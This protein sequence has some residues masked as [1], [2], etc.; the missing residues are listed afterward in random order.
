[1]SFDLHALKCLLPQYL[2]ALGCELVFRGDNHFETA[3]PIHRGT[4]RNFKADRKPDG[5]WVWKCWSQCGGDGGTIIDLHARLQGDAPRSYTNLESLA[6]TLGIRG[7]STTQPASRM[8]RPISQ[9]EPTACPIKTPTLSNEEQETIHRSRLRF[10]DAFDQGKL[11]TMARTLGFE[12]WVLRWVAMGRSGIGLVDGKL[13]YIYPHGLKV[14]TNRHPRFIW[15]IGKA[16]EPWRFDWVKPETHTVY[17]TEG[18]S[19]CMAL[20]ATGVEKESGVTCI[21]S[22]GTSFRQSWGPLFSGKRVILCFDLD[23]AGRAAT[24]RTA[25]ILKPYTK[26]VL[27][28]RGTLS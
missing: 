24:Q 14:R 21:A 23:D 15:K 10:S 27:T 19:D 2:R 3:C 17:L 8:T 28:W 5:T 7:S 22:P 26:E 9:P 16:C 11:D 20:V 1:M 6:Q 12:P 4:N 18:E 25:A 13:A